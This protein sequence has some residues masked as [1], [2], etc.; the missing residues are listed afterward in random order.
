MNL[1]EF[2]AEFREVLIKLLRDQILNLRCSLYSRT[3]A[4]LDPNF[5]RSL[6]LI[7]ASL[8]F[9]QYLTTATNQR[10]GND[11]VIAIDR[12]RGVFVDDQF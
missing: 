9:S 11:F 4:L 3:G 7:R 10:S 2:F 6:H 8:A 1:H 5:G 12:E